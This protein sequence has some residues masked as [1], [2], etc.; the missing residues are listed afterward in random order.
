LLG[1][2]LA[3]VTNDRGV[4][5][6]SAAPGNYLVVAWRPADG[7]M[8]LE[9]AISKAIKEQGT[10]LTLSPNNRKQLDIRLP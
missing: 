7:P 9:T 5:T 2:N 4:F 1:G 3:T 6:L 10:G 8:A